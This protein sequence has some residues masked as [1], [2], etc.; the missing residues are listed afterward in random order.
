MKPR[1][2]DFLVDKG[3]SNHVVSPSYV[4]TRTVLK[5]IHSQC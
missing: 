3:K 5:A 1:H 2:N 4:K